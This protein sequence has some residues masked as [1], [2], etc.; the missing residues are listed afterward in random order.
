MSDFVPKIPILLQIRKI[1]FE[2]YNDV[3]ARFT[4]DEIFDILKQGGDIDPSWT[5]DDLEG[6]ILE[7]CHSNLT[8]N[9]AQNFTTI[10]LKLFEPVEKLHCSACNSDVYLGKLEERV[11]TSCKSAI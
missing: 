6:Q 1:I 9:I 3:D 4:N 8:R 11:C 7:L 10:W 5:V 2:K